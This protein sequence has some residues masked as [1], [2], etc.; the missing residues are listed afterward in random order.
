[1][2]AYLI[3]FLKVGSILHDWQLTYAELFNRPAIFSKKKGYHHMIN[4]HIG[5]TEQSNSPKK[6]L[7]YCEDILF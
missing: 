1:M 4:T 3:T 2:V 6:S 7:K 5:D